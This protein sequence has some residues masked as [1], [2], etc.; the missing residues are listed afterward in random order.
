MSL[1]RLL[2]TRRAHTVLTLEFAGQRF[3][4]GF[5]QEI[6]GG[7]VQPAIVEVFADAKRTGS[8]AQ[9]QL[10]DSCIAISL[11]LRDLY[12]IVTHRNRR[13]MANVF[14]TKELFK[15]SRIDEGAP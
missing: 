9:A 5:G 2:P 7:V 14:K 13:A 1:R 4:V 15:P 8:D 10:T 12:S 6:V 3:H 11:L